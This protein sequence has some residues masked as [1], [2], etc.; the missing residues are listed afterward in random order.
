M[1]PN[2]KLRAHRI[3]LSRRAAAANKNDFQKKN[4]LSLFCYLHLFAHICIAA[5]AAARIE[6]LQTRARRFCINYWRINKK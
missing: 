5:A 3:F 6:L 4:P 2:Q 1:R